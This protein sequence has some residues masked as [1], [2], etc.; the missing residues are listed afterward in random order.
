MESLIGALLILF[1]G[2]VLGVL[3]GGGSILTVPILVYFF[4]VSALASTSYSLVIVGVTSLFGA[5]YHWRRGRLQLGD[6]L[7]FSI[8]AAIGVVSARQFI[9]PLLPDQFILLF[10]AV[11]IMVIAIFMLRTQ[12]ES[13]STDSEAQFSVWKLAIE[14]LVVGVLTGIVGAGGGFMIVP[15][16]VL[17][18]GMCLRR[19]IAT[20]LGIIAIKSLVG[21]GSD[22]ASGFVVDWVFLV[23]VLAGTGLGMGIGLWLQPYLPTGLLRKGF[24]VMVFVLGVLMVILEAF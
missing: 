12:D 10:F 5:L 21:F 18:G 15:A 17:F 8:P 9:L 4:G 11:L 20:S 7:K 6:V 16:L 14:G 13:E 23:Q 3:G 24:G 1:M 2:L 19:A 22:L